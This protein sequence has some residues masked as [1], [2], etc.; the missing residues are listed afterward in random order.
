MI[1]IFANES[2]TSYI[3]GYYWNVLNLRFLVVHLEE[4]LKNKIRTGKNQARFK[5]RIIIDGVAI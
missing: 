5:F 3:Y 2:F 1:A 4:E